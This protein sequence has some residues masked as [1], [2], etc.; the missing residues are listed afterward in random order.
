VLIRRARIGAPLVTRRS[1]LDRGQD[2]VAVAG[3][4]WRLES[5]M[6]GAA[7]MAA[8]VSP[9][10]SGTP[11]CSAPTVPTPAHSTGMMRATLGTGSSAQSS[12]PKVK[13]VVGHGSPNAGA[14]GNR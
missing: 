7:I 5:S 12:T 14:A 4:R 10:S 3:V 1:A 11:N 2:H 13:I 9:K 6:I 8:M